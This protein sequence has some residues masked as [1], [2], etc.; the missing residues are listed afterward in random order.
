MVMELRYGKVFGNVQGREGKFYWFT[1]K[2][3]QLTDSNML[4]G[5]NLVVESLA[6]TLRL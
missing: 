1:T 4:I 6:V 5:C 2:D 3:S